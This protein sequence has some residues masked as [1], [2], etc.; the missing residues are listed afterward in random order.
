MAFYTGRVKNADHEE[1]LI[2]M[3]KNILCLGIAAS[4]LMT[5]PTCSADAYDI[6]YQIG[7]AMGQSASQQQ[8]DSAKTVQTSEYKNE[9]Y[10][11]GKIKKILLVCSIPDGFSQF[12]DDN[13]AVQNSEQIIQKRL[14]GK[15]FTVETMDGIMSKLSQEKNINLYYMVKSDPQQAY[16][17]IGDYVKGNFD[18][19]C[20]VKI[21]SYEM[22]PGQASMRAEAT[23]DTTF[24]DAKLGIPIY[25][26][27]RQYIRASLLLAPNSPKDM[28][29]KISRIFVNNFAKKVAS[30]AK[31]K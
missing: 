17:I 9:N 3:K 5:M 8:N 13:Y 4:F 19:T 24:T 31:K 28:V 29:E 22:I 12:V 30:D 6:G 14:E 18:A 23:L 16:S 10:N 25:S 11:A 1:R 2:A 7:Q 27:R 26:Y 15:G 21:F 20:D